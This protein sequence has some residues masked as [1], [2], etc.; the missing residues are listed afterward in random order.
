MG[1]E[2][3]ATASTEPAD[4]GDRDTVFGTRTDAGEPSLTA[5]IGYLERGGQVGRYLV[6]GI[7]GRGAMGVVYRAHDPELD[8]EVALK[9][10]RDSKADRQ[11]RLAREAQAL[12]RLNHPNVVTV[13]DVGTVE[14][15]LYVAME[16]VRG[17]PLDD[18]QEDRP[19]REVVDTYV[20]AGRGLV[21]AHAQGLV[22][23]DF[24]PDNVIVSEDGIPRVLDFGLARAV[25][26]ESPSG[27]SMS[28][29]L[30][31]VVDSSGSAP[32]HD[33]VT[34][35]GAVVGTP[36]YMSPEQWTGLPADAAA[37]QYSF[38][39]SLWEGLF[40]RPPHSGATLHDL[41]R[42]VVEG[43]PPRVPSKS[44]V[45]SWVVAIVQRGLAHNSEERWPSMQELLDALADDPARRR[46]RWIVAGVALS[47]VAA[48]V[49]GRTAWDGAQRRAC[50]REAAVID[51][52][53]NEE[54]QAALSKLLHDNPTGLASANETLDALAS[55]H[56]E[57]ANESCLAHRLEGTRTEHDHDRVV[58]C[59]AE[60]R[61]AME[62]IVS[63]SD[64]VSKSPHD[65]LTAILRLLPTSPCRDLDSLRL[66]APAPADA[67]SQR[68]LE[69]IRRSAARASALRE[70]APEL[71]LELART[72]LTRAEA[73]G[74]SPEL[75]A[76]H[77][78]VGVALQDTG[79]YAEAE[80]NYAEGYFIA[81]SN[82]DDAAAVGAANSMAALFADLSKPKEGRHWSRLAEA[83]LRRARQDQT[84][85]QA[86]WQSARGQVEAADGNYEDAH[87]YFSAA[88]E[89]RQR[90]LGND[91]LLVAGSEQNLGALASERGKFD[92]ARAHH[93]A[94]MALFN[95]RLG[96]DHPRVAR[97]LANLA[98]VAERDGK[99]ELAREHRAHALS[100]LE[101]AYGPDHPY[102]AQ[103]LISMGQAFLT[104]GEPERAVELLSR[105]VTIKERA[106]GDDSP[107]VAKGLTNLGLAHALSG[108]PGDARRLL[109]RA[110]EIN[111]QQLGREHVQTSQ[112]LS[113]LA[114]ILVALDETSEAREHLVEA[115]EI[116]RKAYPP[117]HNKLG[118]MLLQLGK[119][120][121][122][123]GQR[124]AAIPLL[125]ESIEIL[126]PKL[127]PKAPMIAMAR[128]LLEQARE[129]SPPESE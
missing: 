56:R 55:E 26:G 32:L 117:G 15:R 76:A 50:E 29:P 14:G 61:Y 28:D 72:T 82:G 121:V 51:E 20:A 95:A 127:G 59:L 80:T 70:A 4:S 94:A 124:A 108:Q 123:D 2:E 7:I 34:R 119:L 12:A 63:F 129:V 37:D 71:G 86:L 88:L 66:T 85:V 45:P 92:E 42:K 40:G 69:E 89:L 53:W 116:A 10:L 100:I 36:A 58:A 43:K 101:P 106:F 87:Y 3:S 111:E 24:K 125:E 44:G 31:P 22:H 96:P 8:R 67:E 35:A 103:L 73:L 112:A 6:L 99:V 18:W 46:R 64:P 105:A 115:I 17:T 49:L 16:L 47:V 110:V 102:V 93:E 84:L 128:D 52:V 5:P 33:K 83:H 77:T 19:W 11:T 48:G 98:T 75:S 9:L 122:D 74:W 27:A 120:L 60:H 65:T 114:E 30:T 41:R 38:C 90:L 104:T 23:R 39:A 57:V 54:S 78:R 62:S 81:A 68:E 97:A 21:A 107:E 118:A 13:H 113:V 126:E 1:S 79:R 109:E 25:P 91:H